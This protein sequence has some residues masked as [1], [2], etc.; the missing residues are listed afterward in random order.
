MHLLGSVFCAPADLES[1][2]QY[3]FVIDHSRCIGCHACTVACKAEN[4]V[5]L[6]KFRTWVKYV[7]H[8]DFPQ[9]RRS[10]AVLRCNQC[11]D[12]PC[13]AICPVRAL[14]KRPDGIVDIDPDRC[15]GCKSCLQGCPYDA[16]YIN[17]DTGLAEKCHFC[18]HRTEIGLAPACAVVC[19]T[20]AIIP[21]DFD[22]ATSRVSRMKAEGGLLARKTE[23]GTEPNVLYREVEPA[24]IEPLDTHAAG[25]LLWAERP[26]GTQPDVQA[27]EAMEH[28]AKARTTY[29]V[30]H[31]P[32]WGWKI[33]SYLFTKSIAAGLALA[34]IPLIATLD[35]GLAVDR[36][37]TMGLLGLSLVFLSLTGMLLVHDLKR[38]DRFWYI[39][40]FG[41]P[42]SWLVKGTWIIMGFGALVSVWIALLAAGIEIGPTGSALLLTLTGLGA[43]LTAC[44]TAWLFGQAKGRVLW[45]QRGLWVS[46]VAH[47]CSAGPALILVIALATGLDGGAV[48]T[49]RVLLIF[50]LAVHLL[51]CFSESFL[52]PRRREQE[53]RRAQRLLTHGPF[54]RRHWWLGIVLGAVLPLLLLLFP[55][56]VLFWWL[57]AAF[58]LVGLFVEQDTLVRA[59]QALPIS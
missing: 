52:A 22:D 38:P 49:S 10:F 54:A 19:P 55:L 44:Y 51:L 14:G 39:L 28:R 57:A 11:S 26:P 58:S 48:E 56:P 24:G 5:P 46:L 33:S 41:N 40:R 2:L 53:Y 42:S 12:A 7:E 15:I 32:A 1:R 30:G 36:T 43:I 29:D 13:V 37:V 3:G 27:F 16:L 4:D 35:T 18:A 50:G 59:G 31:P 21:G 45:L 34:A 25:G 8:G 20:E 23:A 6:G 47:A 9:V 17:E